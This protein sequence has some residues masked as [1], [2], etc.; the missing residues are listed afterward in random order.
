[1]N[2]HHGFNI[3]GVDF[4]YRFD[5]TF[6]FKQFVFAI[7]TRTVENVFKV[8]TTE[9]FIKRFHFSKARYLYNACWPYIHANT[10]KSTFI[11]KSIYNPKTKDPIEL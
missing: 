9:G 3:V 1:V 2:T 4:L 10:F 8:R 11:S 6:S 5:V 7:Y